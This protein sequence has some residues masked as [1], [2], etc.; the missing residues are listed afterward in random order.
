[1]DTAWFQNNADRCLRRIDNRVRAMNVISP[2]IRLLAVEAQGLLS[3]LDQVKPLALL[4]SSVPAAQISFQAQ[5]LIE[6]HLK[7]GRRV[8]RQ[9]IDKFLIWLDS[10][11]GVSAAMA[12]RRYTLLRLRFNAILSKFDIF[13]DAVTQ[14]SEHDTGIWL[15][16]L[17]VLAKDAM[18]LSGY[19]TPPPVICYLDRGAG[20]AIR[21]ARTRLPGGGQNPVAIIRIPRERMIGSGIASSLVHEVGHQ[22]AACLDLVDSL[23]NVLKQKIAVEPNSHWQYWNR[24][25]SEIIADFWSVARIGIGST[26]GLMGVVSLPKA[27][28]F[29][30]NMDDPH[31]I[32]WIRVMLSCEMGKILY[33]HRQWQQLSDIWEA[34][35]PLSGLEYGKKALFRELVSGMTQFVRLLANHK[36]I[37]LKGAT[38]RT[39][40][41]SESYR[42]GRLMGSFE[43]WQR[44]PVDMYKVPP[45]MAFAVLGQ[46]KWQGR[47]SARQEAELICKLFKNWALR[48]VPH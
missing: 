42:P 21:R 3:R 26:L 2:P 18:T 10:N 47:I 43:N 6:N 46:A 27:F 41:Y 29:R 5:F 20:A 32:P 22:A 9:E 40:L 16:G 25:I 31:P 36:L 12:Q 17:D 37:R 7:P 28:V 44:S 24:W 13:A 11:P 30:V 34:Y 23:R 4:D 48:N 19:F 1:M 45:A 39:V 38:L 15:A 35:Y 33:P 14:R 8:L